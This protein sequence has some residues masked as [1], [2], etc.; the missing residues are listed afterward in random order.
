MKKIIIIICIVFVGCNKN[1]SKNN[2]KIKKI[3]EP[4]FIIFHA[5]TIKSGE[6]NKVK[7][8][9]VNKEFDKY[10]N[11]YLDVYYIIKDSIF[12][13]TIKD[14]DGFEYGVLT[15]AKQKDTLYI[16]SFKER[17]KKII[18]FFIY[19]EVEIP[20]NK[21]SVRILYNIHKFGS[22]TYIK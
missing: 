21:D 14:L 12:N 13:G 19:D 6:L 20:V 17:G 16:N 22:P 9:F 5:D 11:R 10:P 8:E 7:Y 3:D 4:D 18:T 2:S 1:D 15:N